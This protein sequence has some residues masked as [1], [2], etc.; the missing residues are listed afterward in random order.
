MKCPR[1]EVEEVS[2]QCSTIVGAVI[3]QCSQCGL[4]ISRFSRTV[5]GTQK[6]LLQCSRNS[7]SG[8]PSI[9]EYWDCCDL[10]VRKKATAEQALP[11][12]LFLGIKRL[13][14]LSRPSVQ[15]DYT[16]SKVN[17]AY[18]F[19]YLDFYPWWFLPP[20]YWRR[21]HSSGPLW[22][23]KHSAIMMWPLPPLL[24]F[25]PRFSTVFY[26]EVR[27]LKPNNWNCFIT[28]KAQFVP[29]VFISFFSQSFQ[30]QKFGLGNFYQHRLKKDNSSLRT[31]LAPQFQMIE[32]HELS[33]ILSKSLD[34][35]L[36][37]F[38][39]LVSWVRKQL[40]WPIGIKTK[41]QWIPHSIFFGIT[42]EPELVTQM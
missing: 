19:W 18:R 6:S 5:P 27:V 40:F 1:L 42:Q 4:Q 32:F 39:S 8:Y 38:T 36:F 30:R 33:R 35:V 25:L 12:A 37:L 3:F 2:L 20:Y 41:A 31:V 26:N 28:T 16:P 7:G 10:A 34:P 22:P 23:K 11:P 15:I 9:F 29:W 24:F 17:Y 14:F 21:H 13:E